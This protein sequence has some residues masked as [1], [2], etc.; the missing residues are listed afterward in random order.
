MSVLVILE[1]GVEML[2]SKVCKTLSHCSK[3]E[4]PAARQWLTKMKR[5]ALETLL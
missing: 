3:S 5:P 4:G 2:L 1:P